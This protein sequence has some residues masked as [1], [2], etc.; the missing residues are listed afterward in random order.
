MKAWLRPSLS[1]ML[2]AVPVAATF[3]NAA[4]LIVI[5]NAAILAARRNRMD[6]AMGIAIGSSVAGEKR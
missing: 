6:L 4:E 2:V 3:G 1:W 5:G